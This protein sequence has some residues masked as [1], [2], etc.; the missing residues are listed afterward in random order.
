MKGLTIFIDIVLS[1]STLT[2][3]AN[4]SEPN[5]NRQKMLEE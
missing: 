4:Q 3:M 2:F 1:I 5:I